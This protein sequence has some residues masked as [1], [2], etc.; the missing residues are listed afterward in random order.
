MDATVKEWQDEAWAGTESEVLGRD[1]CINT[2]L[3][4][5]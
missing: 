5:P 1:D 4:S 2:V 3:P